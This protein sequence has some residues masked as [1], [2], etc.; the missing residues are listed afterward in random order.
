[1]LM[2]AALNRSQTFLCSKFA[3]LS[4][5]VDASLRN[6]TSLVSYIYV[7]STMCRHLR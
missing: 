7:G 1:M 2:L 6:F 5:I 4:K 3:D